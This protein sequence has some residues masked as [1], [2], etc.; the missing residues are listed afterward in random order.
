MMSIVVWNQTA[1]N[2]FFENASIPAFLTLIPARRSMGKK[3]VLAELSVLYD[4][5]SLIT[6]RCDRAEMPSDF[7]TEA[8][9]T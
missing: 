5:P 4:E 2:S 3:V 7:A 6:T 8:R 1:E 9:S